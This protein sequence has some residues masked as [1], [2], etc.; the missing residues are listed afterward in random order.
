VQKG[1][2]G[3]AALVVL[4][5]PEMLRERNRKPG[6]KEAMAIAVGVMAADG[7]Q[8]FAQRGVL[9]GLEDPGFGFH[10]VVEL[11][12]TPAGSFSNILTITACAAAT[13]LFRTL[14][15]SEVSNSLLSGN[16]ERM[17]CR[18]PFGS[19]GREIVSVAPNAQA[20]IVPW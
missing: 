18:I 9:D 11:S 8:P 6:D 3:Q 12:G 4:A 19:N 5:H 20:C 17:R 1:S 14:P 15:R 2:A 13:P 16:A 7:R 10:N